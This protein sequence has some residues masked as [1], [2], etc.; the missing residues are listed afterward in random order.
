VVDYGYAEETRVWKTMSTAPEQ[1]PDRLGRR[2]IRRLIF[3]LLVRA[4]RRTL[5]GRQLILSDGSTERWLKPEIRAFMDDLPGIADQLR[6]SAYLDDLPT[7]GSRL[8]VE[9]SV[10]TI[11]AY[12][13]MLARGVQAE[14]ARQVVADIGWLVYLFGLRMTSLPFRITTRDPAKRLRR[15]LKLLLRFPFNGGGAPGYEVV[16]SENDGDTLTHF[17]HCPPQS[18]VR[19]LVQEQGDQGDLDAFYESW[20]LYD[21]PGADAIAADSQ[22]GH[23]QRTTTLSRGD[24]VCDMCWKGSLRKTQV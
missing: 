4:G 24:S 11:A 10:F 14:C 22:R 5:M 18:F 3:R 13:L 20:C 2:L 6:K 8:M 7:Q 1:K 17:T 12:R 16:V 23:Y 15:T 19:K 9:I 21:W